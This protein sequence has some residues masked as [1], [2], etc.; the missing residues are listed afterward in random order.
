MN[1]HAKSRLIPEPL[2]TLRSEDTGQAGACPDRTRAIPCT[3]R[4][5][6]GQLPEPSHHAHNLITT[7]ASVLI[8]TREV[9]IRIIRVAHEAADLKVQAMPAACPMRWSTKGCHGY[10]RTTPHASQP[11]L[12]HMSQV[13][14]ET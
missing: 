7:G 8:W 9:G 14:E 13:T 6:A 12:T 3:A 11:G 4:A 5:V 10:S 2:R 1:V